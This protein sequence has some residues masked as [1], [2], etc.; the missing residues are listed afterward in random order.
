MLTIRQYNKVMHDWIMMLTG[1]SGSNVRPQK[2]KFGFAL[3][4]RDGKPISFESS[5]AMFYFGF[6]DSALDRNYSVNDSAINLKRA[7]LNVTFIGDTSENL[8]SQFM[9]TS[10]GVQSRQYLEKFGFAI[11]GN[12]EEI[13]TDKEYSSKWFRR[14]TIKVSLNCKVEFTPACGT[15]DKYIKSI[16]YFEKQVK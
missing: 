3:T 1:L 2:D 4:T 8:G 15:L 13:M 6:E 16:P 14:R 12:P 5:V 11:M 9:A 7:S 10:L